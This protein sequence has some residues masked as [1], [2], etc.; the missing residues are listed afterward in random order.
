MSSAPG[1][2]VAIVCQSGDE[3]LKA[4]YAFAEQLGLEAVTVGSAEGSFLERLEGLQGVDFAVILLGVGGTPGELLLETGFLLA[5]PGPAR[6]CLLV[7][8]GG[9]PGPELQ[10]L[11]R[12]SMDASGLWRLLLAREMRRAGLDVDL[13]RA[14]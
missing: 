10:D 2:R 14:I 3:A 12:H 4:A 7:A 5:A 11:P 9:Q 13:N 8:D 6:M 1:S